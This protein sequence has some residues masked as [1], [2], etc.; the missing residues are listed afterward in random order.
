MSAQSPE[1]NTI[2]PSFFSGQGNRFIARCKYVA[3][4]DWP[5]FTANDTY[6]QILR[7]DQ[8]HLQPGRQNLSYAIPYCSLADVISGRFC[9]L[10]RDDLPSA[11]AYD[12]L[13]MTLWG[14]TRMPN[15]PLGGYCL[16]NGRLPSGRHWRAGCK[17]AGDD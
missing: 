4:P 1:C 10:Q 17:G 5:L 12:Q 6:C 2:F 14:S 9:V 8:Y 16:K 11:K 13:T 7:F 3:R 15:C